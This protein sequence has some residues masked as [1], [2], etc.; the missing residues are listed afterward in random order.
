M[1]QPA[2]EVRAVIAAVQPQLLQFHGQEDNVWCTQFA[3]P[4]FKAIPMAGGADLVAAAAEYPNAAALLLD[5][6][7][8]GEIGGQGKV[9]DWS[10]IGA[11]LNKNLLLAGGLNPGNVAAAVR[12]VRPWAVDVSSGVEK[13]PGI[14]DHALMMQFCEQLR[15][16]EDVG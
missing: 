2:A 3:L 10:T 12:L 11:G 9:F 14:K 7:G 5:S 15:L 8:I 6:H 16:I 13:A 4:F 1:D